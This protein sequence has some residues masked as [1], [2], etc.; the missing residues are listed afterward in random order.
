MKLT[1]LGSGTSHGIPV[2]A[3][4]CPVCKS[5]NPKDKR[6]RSSVY[7]ETDEGK[8]V[9]I[10]IG[11][12]FR[13]QALE[14]NIRKVDALLLTHS[15]ADHLHGIDDL[16]IFSAAMW[17]KPDA[18]HQ[19]SLEQYNAPPIPVYANR[20]TLDDI[21]TRFAYFFVEVKE[22]GGR[23]KVDLHE[24][25]EPFDFYG[26]KITPVPMMHGHLPTTGWLFSHKRDDGKVHALAY[27]TDCSFISD[28][29]I[30]LIN[31]NCDVLDELII[32]GLRVREHSTHF[33]FLQAMEVADKMHPRAVW[34]THITHEANHKEI[35]KYLEE[36]KKEFENLKDINVLPAY[37]RL[38]IEV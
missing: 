34:M 36:N 23:A 24:A 19:K 8:Y 29:S 3:C 10:D 21:T 17:K 37:D 27:L 2:I 16:R 32:D 13:I 33:S 7:I 25:T 18:I 4:D 12:E 28:E 14:N 15:H 31:N 11:P 22:G 1:I 20:S 9:L 38:I 30:A 35:T 6:Y 26:T 5:S